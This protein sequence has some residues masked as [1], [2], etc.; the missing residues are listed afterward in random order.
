MPREL[1]TVEQVATFLSLK[2][3]TVRAYAERRT[4]PHVRIG[5]RLR[6]RPEDVEAFVER[7]WVPAKAR[8]RR[9]ALDGDM[10]SVHTGYRDTK[11]V[12]EGEHGTDEG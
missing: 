11:P 6:F 2:A 9:P 10:L 4:L 1:W 8:R 7:R 12:Q 5:G 3:G